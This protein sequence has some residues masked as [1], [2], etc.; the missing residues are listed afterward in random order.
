M[1][2]EKNSLVKIYSDCWEYIR[3]SKN[4]IWFVLWIFVIFALIGGL[5]PA[6]SELTN[7][8]SEMLQKLSAETS[9]FTNVFQWIF[10]LF[11]NNILASFFG[12]ISG[13]FLGFWP[14]LASVVNGYLVGFVGKFAISTSGI[15]VLWKLFPHGIF[16][17]PALFI[18]LGLGVKLGSFIFQKKKVDSLKYYF[19]MSLKV[20][21]FVV[22]PLLIVAAIIEGSLIF[23]LS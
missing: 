20:F 8:I 11:K 17:L 6:S 21:I 2:K 22:I 12:L 1:V 3:S 4:Y 14:I 19:W 16:E 13:V 23:Y 10:Y 15:F 7:L 18:S 5:F 9:G